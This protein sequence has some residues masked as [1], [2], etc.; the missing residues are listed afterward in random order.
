[1][2]LRRVSVRRGAYED[3]VKAQRYCRVW[4]AADWLLGTMVMCRGPAAARLPTLMT[5][6]LL[7][8]TAMLQ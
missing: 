6:P 8:G 1:L 3:V 7:A 4:P 5:C 2:E